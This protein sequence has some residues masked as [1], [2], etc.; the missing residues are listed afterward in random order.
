MT[1]VDPL[2]VLVMFRAVEGS[3]YRLGAKWPLGAPPSRV[4]GTPVDCSG[5]LRWLL[6][7]CGLDLPDGSANQREYVENVLKWRKIPYADLHWTVADGGRLFVAFKSPTKSGHGH[8]WLVNAGHSMESC[9]SGGV[10]R[11]PW[12]RLERYASACFE[13][14][15]P[16]RES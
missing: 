9:S 4:K 13:V 11:R 15:T 3:P 1:A 8:V 7:E 10:C 12:K 6:Y 14:P 5:F 2:K 16:A